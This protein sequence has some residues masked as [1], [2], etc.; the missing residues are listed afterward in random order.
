MSYL[1][2]F[3]KN[4]VKTL[5]SIVGVF[6]ILT[7]MGSIHISNYP[8]AQGQQS[9]ATNAITQVQV[10]GGNATYP[11]FG[12]NPQTVQVNVGSKVVWT[13]S[14]VD[15]AEPHT[16]SFINNSITMAA[17][18]APFAVPS[19]TKF[20]P[21]P[22]GANSE[23]NMIPGTNANGM[24]TVI[25]NNARSYSPTIIDSTGNAKVVPPNG[26]FVVSGNE[27]YINSGWL[28][29][30]SQEKAYPGSSNTFTVAFQKSGTYHY[31]CEL[32]PWMVGQV[33]VK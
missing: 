12:Y 9:S 6:V 13:T 26:N 18:D 7:A 11:F 22:P 29:P 10:G 14:N 15:F 20:S 21:I 25:V 4:K 17:P 32:H 23:P 16:V 8:T 1:N 5:V 33:V 30:K 31:L 3:Y 2:K 28:I 27:Q 24:N 19:S